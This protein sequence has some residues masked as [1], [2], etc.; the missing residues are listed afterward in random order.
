MQSIVSTQVVPQL[1]LWVQASAHTRLGGQCPHFQWQALAETA[2]SLSADGD[3]T[4]QPATIPIQPRIAATHTVFIF[5]VP[6][7]VGR[8]EY[9][10]SDFAV[11][12]GSRGDLT[13]FL[14]G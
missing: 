13:L 6:Q 2:A 9:P 1:P 10:R 3:S 12:E 7:T 8:V 14:V 5:W 11:K 4:P